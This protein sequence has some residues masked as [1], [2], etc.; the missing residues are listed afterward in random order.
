M[1]DGGSCIRT[2]RNLLLL[3]LSSGARM[4]GKQTGSERAIDLTEGAK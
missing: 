4:L 3:H 2:A 1:W